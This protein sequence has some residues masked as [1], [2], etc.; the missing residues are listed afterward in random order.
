MIF[1]RDLYVFFRFILVQDQIAKISSRT[2]DNEILHLLVENESNKT[3]IPKMN[4][5]NK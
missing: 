3:E 2:T 1:L 4:A 5:D